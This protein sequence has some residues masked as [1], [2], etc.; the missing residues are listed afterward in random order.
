[1]MKRV[2]A[3]LCLCLFTTSI[4]WA[5]DS[6]PTD[7]EPTNNDASPTDTAGGEPVPQAKP[8][9]AMD[10][11]FTD[12]ATKEVF[13]GWLTIEGAGEPFFLMGTGVRV[14]I[15]IQVYA[16]G[17]YV[18]TTPAQEALAAWK[19]KSKEDLEKDDGFYDTLLKG[20]FGKSMRL[21]MVFDV[22]AEDFA[23][24]FRD[25]IEPRI[26]SL[27]PVGDQAAATT[28]LE[29]FKG[30]FDSPAKKGQE[31]IMTWT[32]EDKLDVTIDGTKKGSIDNKGLALC[33]FDIYLG[34]DPISPDAKKA[35][36][37]GIKDLLP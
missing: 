35:F 23:N 26:K 6:K 33:L 7:T 3:I 10:A 37:G 18:E 1:M 22:S 9:R 19:G 34:K 16:M 25:S 4:W 14:K 24:A 8:T 15:I 32:K 20:K 11:T 21:A 36:A 12:E 27:L 29:T 30:F 28:A 2:L 5:C 13:K 17:L 31:I